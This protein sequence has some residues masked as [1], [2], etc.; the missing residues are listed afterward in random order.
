MSAGSAIS[1]LNPRRRRE[2]FA[3]FAAANPTPVTEL[4]YN[5]TFEL[6]VAVMLSAQSTDKSVN[7]VTA[8]LFRDANTPSALL[9]LGL[10]EL[11][12]A[13]RS[14]GLY[15][16]KARHLLATCEILTVQH[17]GQ[18]PNDRAALEALPG[19]GRKTASV[20]LNIAYKMA[21]IAV[22]THIFRVANRTGLA[23]GKTVAEVERKL[24][25]AVP[26]AYLLH[27]HHWLILHGRYTCKARKPDCPTC[28]IADLCAY[29]PKVPTP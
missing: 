1:D 27:A 9:A 5:S 23:P 14:L 25:K 7:R 12:R 4:Q 15:K 13:L 19:V 20:I 28:I 16:S 2:I 11:E 26:E 6:L 10:P 22:D 24:M 29:Q 8:A 21:V 18:V 17:Q 3:R